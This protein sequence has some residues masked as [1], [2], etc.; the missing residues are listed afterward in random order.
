MAVLSLDFSFLCFLVAHQGRVSS[1]PEL[2]FRVVAKP[3]L[4][5]QIAFW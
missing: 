3:D 4:T 1:V 2:L 5:W